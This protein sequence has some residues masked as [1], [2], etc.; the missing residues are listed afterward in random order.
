MHFETH[1]HIYTIHKQRQMLEGGGDTLYDFWTRKLVSEREREA[2]ER[3]EGT[4]SDVHARGVGWSLPFFFLLFAFSGFF[5]FQHHHHRH[6]YHWLP[7]PPLAFCY[8]YLPTSPTYSQ[9]TS[10]F[11]T[12]RQ[13]SS[14]FRLMPCLCTLYLVGEEAN[15]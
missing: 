11:D 2:G 3:G 1:R 5:G 10:R 8:S 7:H 15:K 12:L 9:Y 6:Y 13:S 4:T 14:S